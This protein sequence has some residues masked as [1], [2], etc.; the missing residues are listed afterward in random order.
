[1]TKPRAR[2]IKSD[3]PSPKATVLRLRGLS[4][5]GSKYMDLSFQ[6]KK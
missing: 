1:M 3:P 5:D 2:D 4:G 6:P